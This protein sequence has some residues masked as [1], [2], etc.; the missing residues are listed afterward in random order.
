[1]QLFR[2]KRKPESFGFAWLKKNPLKSLEF[3]DGARRRTVTLVN[4]NLRNSITRHRASIRYVDA[5]LVVIAHAHAV[6]A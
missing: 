3:P 1:M 2:S 6:L 5:Y 4:V